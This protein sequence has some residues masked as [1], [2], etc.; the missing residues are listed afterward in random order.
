YEGRLDELL[1]HVEEL[2]AHAVTLDEPYSRAF[3]EV[4]RV[5]GHAYRGETT[6]ATAALP[7]LMAAADESASPTMLAFAH[8]C[9]GE[10]YLDTDPERAAVSLERAIDLAHS[11]DNALV[12]G[13]SQVSL[14]SLLGRTGRT[15]EALARF[16][17][18]ISH[19]RRL[20]NYT[21]QLTTL[22]NLVELLVQIGEDEL[23]AMLH[24]AVTEA[25][26]AP[27]FG[28]EAQ[29]LAAAWERLES[30]LGT[31]VAASAATRGR[32]LTPTG[33]SGE[34]LQHLDALLGERTA[35]A[36]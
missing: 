29:R 22:R 27:S 3:A 33:V 8:Y 2:H 31:E 14:A 15:E 16:R 13:V 10:C 4:C 1:Q 30:R 24:G 21:H 35:Q 7:E 5:I 6:A 32:G 17:D 11:V 12:A 26:A 18:V 25:S 36:G 9:D 28:L 34:I 23:A 20:G 19:W